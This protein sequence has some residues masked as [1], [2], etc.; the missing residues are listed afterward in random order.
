MSSLVTPAQPPPNLSRLEASPVPNG[1][2]MSVVV[3]SSESVSPS[4][5]V[6]A[7]HPP[8]ST[9]A[10]FAAFQGVSHY[11]E[12]NRIGKGAYGTVYLA[13]DTQK[14][15]FVALKKMKFCLTEDGVPMAILREIS[16]L[17]QL[18]RFDHPNIVRLLDITHGQR[19]EREMSLHLIFEHVHQDLATY[20]EKC[21]SPGLPPA[22]I[23]NLIWQILNGVDFLHSHRIVH[24]DL[25]PQNLL[26]TKDGRV[27]LT[28]FGLARIYDFYSLLTSVVVTLWYRSP[29]VLMGLSYATPV[30]VWAVGCIFAE[31]FILRKALFPGEYE[32]DQLNR[33]FDV[34][35]TPSAEEWPENAAV[36]RSNFRSRTVKDLQDIVPEID[37]E[38]ADLLKK[39]LLFDPHKRITVSDALL[40]PY[41]DDLDKD[42]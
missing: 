23:K 12:I 26:V 33:I 5:S 6:S 11:E 38:G 25:K 34:I 29:E 13:R 42:L 35:G 4:S 28:D 1:R 17:K 2:I 18:E 36:T 16:L 19:Y 15:R 30:D 32:M 24:R 39:T 9:N 31:L 14:D 3:G 21:P 8:R 10:L 37:D 27:K 7:R 22:K 41:F 20:L 40:H